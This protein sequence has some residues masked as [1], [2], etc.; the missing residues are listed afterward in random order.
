MIGK[1]KECKCNNHR[2]NHGK[3][4]DNMRNI[5]EA[6]LHVDW[7]AYIGALIFFLGGMIAIACAILFFLVMLLP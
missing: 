7:E 2:S 1:N 6:L 4:R 5:I 3:V